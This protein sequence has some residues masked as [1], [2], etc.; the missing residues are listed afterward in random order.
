MAALLVQDDLL[1]TFVAQGELTPAEVLTAYA[2][3]LTRGP[4]R[5]V[6]WDLT[7]ATV[8][9]VPSDDVRRLAK[10]LARLGGEHRS[11]G[12][13]A[14]LCFDGRTFGLARMLGT[15][16]EIE[17]FPGRVGV[18][19]EVKTAKAWLTDDVAGP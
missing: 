15:F 4:T 19:R 3:F 17:G 7:L 8:A 9:Q 11:R 12:K 14:I 6:L 16:L 2:D 10:D 13:T 5:L 18:F 1:S